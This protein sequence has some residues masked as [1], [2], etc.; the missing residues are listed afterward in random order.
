[1]SWQVLSKGGEIVQKQTLHT[2]HI[3]L[4][5]YRHVLQVS[6]VERCVHFANWKNVL[7]CKMSMC[8]AFC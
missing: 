6:G 7:C 2:L 3:L 1:M 4:S 5:V 8:M